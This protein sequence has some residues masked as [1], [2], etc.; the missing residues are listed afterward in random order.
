MNVKDIDTIIGFNLRR[1][2][3]S[4]KLSQEKLGQLINN[5]PTKISALENGKEGLG[6]EL[7]TKICNVLNIRPAEFYIEPDTRIINNNDELM[8]IKTLRTRPESRDVLIKIS[9][10][11]GGESEHGS[12]HLSGSGS[13]KAKKSA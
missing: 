2:R 9:E 3:L 5:P 11:Y 13:T 7:M 4:K 8:I 1:L 10:A 12:N 6:K